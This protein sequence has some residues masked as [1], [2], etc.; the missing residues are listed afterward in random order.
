MFTLN[1]CPTLILLKVKHIFNNKFYDK[2]S[3]WKSNVWHLL[4]GYWPKRA[5]FTCLKVWEE[6]K[7]DLLWCCWQS[8]V[9][10]SKPHRQQWQLYCIAVLYF[11]FFPKRSCSFC[12]SACSLKLYRLRNSVDLGT[13]YIAI[14]FFCFKQLDCYVKSDHYGARLCFIGSHL[15]VFALW[16]Q[17]R[18]QI[19]YFEYQHY[20]NCWYCGTQGQ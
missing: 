6:E 7:L 4:N 3:Y 16:R 10:F 17:F 20:S 15:K 8:W 9:K 14:R 12:L 11:Y 1:H 13:V 5:A 2:S 19:A 18:F